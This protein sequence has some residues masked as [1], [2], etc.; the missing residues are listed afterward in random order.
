MDNLDNILQAIDGRL[1]EK[2]GVREAALGESRR[3]VQTSSKVIRAVHRHEW[4]EARRLL[5]EAGSIVAA[6]NEK[7]LALAEI[8]WA[9]Y[10]QDAQ[11]EFAEANL[12][13]ALVRQE[14]LPTPEAL[15][16]ED[17]AYLNGLAEA[18]SE[19]RRYV[20]DLVRHGHLSE[21]D[22][23]LEAMEE[24]YSRLITVDYPHAIT[25]NLRRTTDM[26]RGV[27]ERTRGDV[28]MA[29]KQQELQ[30]ALRGL[31]SRLQ[32]GGN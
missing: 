32:N 20:L 25:D 18:A 5:D 30:Q 29:M 23:L 10:V 27:L 13:L 14:L 4:D 3:L 26:L 9:G 31:E 12:T 22:Q 28:T 11:K 19:L 24:V 8:Y 1:S 6:M 21:A 2:N 15:G 16:V 17:A 7:T